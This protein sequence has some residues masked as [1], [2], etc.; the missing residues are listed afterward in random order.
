LT[1]RAE[2]VVVVIGFWIVDFA[3]KSY[4]QTYISFPRQW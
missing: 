3:R 4:I 1:L 2:S